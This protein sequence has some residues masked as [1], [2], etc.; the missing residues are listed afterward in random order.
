[1]ALKTPA[2]KLVLAA[3][4]AALLVTGVAVLL[5]RL[6]SSGHELAGR[7]VDYHKIY[8]RFWDVACDTA[9]DGTDQGCYIQYVDVYR[10][11]PDFAAAMVEVVVHQGDDGQPD[12]HVRFDIEPGLSFTDTTITVTTPDTDIPIDVSDCPSNTCRFSGAE[13]RAILDRWRTGTAINLTIQEGRDSPATL[14]W[15]LENMGTILDDFATQRQ[16]RDLP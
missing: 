6:T 16:A 9:M 8:D 2:R 3:L 4:A 11:R 12:P 15:P 7:L 10:P 13:G 1:M 5:F 14:R